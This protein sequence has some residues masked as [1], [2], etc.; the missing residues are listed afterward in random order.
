[1]TTK[2]TKTTT[3]QELSTKFTAND[4]KAYE[5]CK[6]HINAY[7]KQTEGLAAKVAV[8]L[9]KVSKHKYYEID[10][11]KGV[12]EFAESRYGLSKG[13][14]SQAVKVIGRFGTEK[15]IVDKWKDYTWTTLVTLAKYNDNEI[16]NEM[17][18]SADMSRSQVRKAAALHDE[19]KD[20]RTDT[21]FIASTS[22]DL[23]KATDADI[24]PLVKQYAAKAS[25]A[26]ED[27][28]TEVLKQTANEKQEEQKAAD[29]VVKEMINQV[30]E[31]SK[32]IQAAID[33]QN[34]DKTYRE[35]LVEKLNATKPIT[36]A[37]VEDVARVDGQGVLHV[38]ADVLQE[39]DKADIKNLLFAAYELLQ[40]NGD[41]TSLIIK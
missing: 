10:G 18:I 21:G 2:S 7:V 26:I 35:K 16:L 20:Y 15:G 37:G 24:A 1:M 6:N 19:L 33:N 32:E 30:A 4:Q 8:E 40:S 5:T 17:Q 25:K 3:K 38:A 23:K 36:L 29:K 28:K 11:Y 14:V 13:S 9:Y 12:G 39:Y 34:T 41:I 31:T 27:K 22:I